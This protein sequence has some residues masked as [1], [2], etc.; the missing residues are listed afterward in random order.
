MAEDRFAARD[1]ER[2]RAWGFLTHLRNDGERLAV[3]LAKLSDRRAEIEP[4]QNALGL[5][6]V[7]N[8]PA[9]GQRQLLD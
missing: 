6:H 3:R 1:R 2:T 4:K 9:Q 8:E 7:A 5:R